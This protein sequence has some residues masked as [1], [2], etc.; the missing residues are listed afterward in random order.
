MIKKLAL[1]FLLTLSACAYKLDIQQGNILSQ[2]DID[3][4]R[5]D[6]TKNQVT[7][8]LGSPVVDDGFA[9]DKWVYLYSYK[10]ANEGRY[11][12]KKLE[13][14]FSGEKLKS[15]HSDSYKVPEALQTKKAPQEKKEK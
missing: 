10:D 1:L 11:T 13:L 7:F 3:K 12:T 9:D 5:P 14:I 8:V 15:A 2:K 4:L 6:L